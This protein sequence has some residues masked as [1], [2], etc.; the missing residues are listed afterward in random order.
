MSCAQGIYIYFSKIPYTP[1]PSTATKMTITNLYN[2]FVNN[3]F[4]CFFLERKLI[5]IKNP[6]YWRN[7]SSH[8]FVS[9]YFQQNKGFLT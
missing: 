6:L 1:S 7:I 3:N 4:L 9:Q 8:L 5:P 2:S